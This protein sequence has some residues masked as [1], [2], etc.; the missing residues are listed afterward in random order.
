MQANDGG[1]LV[2]GEMTANGV[3]HLLAKLFD[4]VGFGKDGMIQSAGDEAALG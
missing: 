4:A 3:A 2:V 1:P